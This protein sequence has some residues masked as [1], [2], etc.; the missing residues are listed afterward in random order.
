M[1]FKFGV[2]D[3]V[4]TDTNKVGEIKA[5]KH[6]IDGKG[7]TV[8]STTKY[9]VHFGSY[10][11]KWV[12]ENDLKEYHKFEFTNKF[13]IGFLNL[14]I[15]THLAEGNFDLVKKYSQLKNKYGV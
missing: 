7:E 11:Y 2:G 12:D 9:Y 1:V 13:E 6:E 8:T 3:K 14:L 10:D 5:C 15:D 4:R